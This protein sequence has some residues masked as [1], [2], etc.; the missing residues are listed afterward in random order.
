[1]HLCAMV[2][3]TVADAMNQ[4]IKVGQDQSPYYIVH[5]DH[6]MFEPR[7]GKQAGLGCCVLG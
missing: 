6:C 2:F 5:I 4:L 3:D 1:M 7:H